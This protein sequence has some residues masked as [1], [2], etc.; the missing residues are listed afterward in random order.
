MKNHVIAKVRS[1][2]VWS[3]PLSLCII[4][5]VI[6]FPGAVL[7][8]PQPQDQPSGE[9]VYSV[10]APSVFFL[11]TTDDSG[12]PTGTATGFVVSPGL[13]ITNAHVARL[14]QIT[15]QA[16]PVSV[17]CQVEQIDDDRDLA[18]CRLRA[19]TLVPPLTFSA[20][21]PQPGATIFAITNPRGLEKTISQGLFAGFRDL[22]GRRF[23]QVSAAIS[24]GSSGGPIVNTAGEVIGV[25]AGSISS[26]QN[27]NFAVPAFE[28]TAFLSRG[29]EPP[30]AG[31]LVT[32]VKR[33][34]KELD[35]IEYSEETDSPWQKLNQR[36]VQI[37]H[38]A[39]NRSNDSAIVQELYDL[40]NSD[41]FHGDLTI[42]AA[43]KALAV[44]MKP[45]RQLNA[46]LAQA[47]FENRWTV[48]S[49]F[50]EAEKAAKKAVELGLSKNV[51]DL[52]LLGDIEQAASNNEAAYVTYKKAERLVRPGMPEARDTYVDLFEAS[53]DLGN[54]IEADSWFVKAKSEGTLSAFAWNEYAHFLDDNDR[55]ADSAMAYLEAYRSLPDLHGYLCQA[56]V[57][58]YLADLLD[59]SLSTT[60][61]CIEVASVKSGSESAV[62][63]AHRLIAAVLNQRG[64]YDDALSHAREAIQIDPSE[65][66]AHHQMA[67]S[68]RGLRRFTEAVTASKTALRLSDGKFAAMHFDLGSAYFELEQWPESVA[69]FKIATEL[70]SKDPVS[71]FN[72]AAGL[73]NE[74]YY[75]DAFKWFQEVARR[76]PDY[77]KDKVARRIQE[78]LSR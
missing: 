1:T 15:A 76:D 19:A 25:A 40:A 53:R 66:W 17:P 70:D 31:S 28:V 65:P 54:I 26:G 43:R 63:R 56:G 59:E 52:L 47:L 22:D 64:V 30:N 10:V 42:E 58:Y 2:T 61:K 21:A 6:V 57:E 9:K 75:D 38:D 49:W 4:Y 11:Q 72:V 8:A 78:L 34:S 3:L 48:A 46:N 77:E 23:A 39:L 55:Y 32:A 73:Y 69:A 12:Q 62:Q 35:E 44:N 33:L 20:K 50:E 45:T 14:G 7:A 67:R 74:R 71:A 41:L 37:F 27:L 68:L 13:L 24:P 5:F 29:S 18:T 51:K 60:R 16:G 36:Y